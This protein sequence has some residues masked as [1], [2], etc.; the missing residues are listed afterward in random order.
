MNTTRSL[1]V[2]AQ[3]LGAQLLGAHLLGAQVA[4]AQDAPVPFTAVA[5]S[6]RRAP[7]AEH[8]IAYGSAAQQFAE[9]RLP[10]G[11][12]RHPVVFLIHGGCWLNAYGVDHVA[13]VA[14]S[15]R[16]RGVA[17]FAVEYRRVGDDGAGDPGTF[18]D[19]R[20]AFDTLNAIAPRHGID[21]SRLALMGHSAGGHLALWLGSEPG[22]DVR[23]IV[24]LAGVTD[25]SG[26]ATPSGCGSG[27]TR[28]MGGAPDERRAQYRAA[29]PLYR[30]A[31]AVGT[32]VVMVAAEGD[33]I[34]PAS[35]AERY[36]ARFPDARIVRVPGGHFD[37]VAPWTPAW[38]RV[39]DVTRELLRASARD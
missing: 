2:A 25:L 15:L 37:L 7:A 20:A 36:V 9:L 30:S 32:A 16:Q 6:A 21:R 38:T 8:R 39:L 23:G 35:E 4:S 27:V 14:E 31:P 18:N 5:D 28:M 11:A 26:F 10:R 19:V 24:S 13:G 3:I 34:V 22:V 29:S 33:R 12:G 1:I 17:V